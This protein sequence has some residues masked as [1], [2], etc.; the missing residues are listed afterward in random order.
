M[1]KWSYAKEKLLSEGYTCV[2]CSGS[3]VYTSAL[4]GVKPLVQWLKNGTD[5]KGF[6]AADKVVGKA[7]AFLYVLLGVQ[8]VYAHVISRPALAV[9]KENGIEVQYGTLVENI[10]NRKGDGICP[11]EEAVIKISDAHE[12]YP[13]ILRKMKEMNIEL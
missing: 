6:Y 13:A 9:L 7:T 10:I 5:V 1:N 12:A 3:T 4:R 2:L 11:F 8:A